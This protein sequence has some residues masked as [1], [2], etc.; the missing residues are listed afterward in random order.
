MA[1]DNKIRDTA[2]A[3]TGILQAVPVYQDALQPAVKEIGAGLQTVAKTV[4]IVLAPVAALVWGYDQL[5]EFVSTKVVEK[6]K[7]VPPDRI[8]TPEPNVVGPALQALRFTGHQETLRELYAN[9]LATALDADTA[10]LAHPAFVDMIR[11]MSPDE[12]RIM[13]LFAS[14][15]P[16]PV[17]DVRVHLKDQEGYQV[18]MRSYSDIGPRSGCSFPNLTPTYLDNLGR[19]GLIESPGALGLGS[20]YLTG[21][22]VYEPLEQ[23]PE[24]AAINDTVV[25]EGHR[26][27]FGRTFVRLTDLGRQFCNACVLE[28]AGTGD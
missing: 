9:L 4:H 3:V 20:P 22:N 17:I 1:E 13:Q 25:A 15:E 28:K 21:A 7:N 26:L 5:K 12:A 24:I 11:N 14:G 8:R 19:L 16:R 10:Q 27:Q 18:I 2:E 23:A 6:L